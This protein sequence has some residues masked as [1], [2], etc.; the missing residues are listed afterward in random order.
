MDLVPVC[1]FCGGSLVLV[2]AGAR[3]CSTR[4]RVYSARR[5]GRLPGELVSRDRWV[6]RDVF[7]RPLTVDGSPASSTNPRTWASYESVRGSSAGVGLGFVLNGDG[8]SCVDLDHV[9]VDGVLDVRAEAFLASLNPF[10]VERSPSGDGVH[11][12]LFDSSPDGRQV[13]SLPDGLK[14]EWY[15]DGRY[16][17][18][19]GERM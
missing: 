18:V 12:W 16:I 19:T 1:Q 9:I 6:R 15:S 13:F 3:F 17:T 5:A 2:R 8:I 10:Y 11:A 4:C 7:K 14:V